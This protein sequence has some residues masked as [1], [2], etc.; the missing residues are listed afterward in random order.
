MSC[1]ESNP[2][3]GS[4]IAQVL[5]RLGPRTV[6]G[7]QGR[8]TGYSI[9]EAIKADEYE[10]KRDAVKNKKTVASVLRTIGGHRLVTHDGRGT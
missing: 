1:S 8:W 5:A 10:R 9:D 3:P 4:S 2:Q 6:E 7:D